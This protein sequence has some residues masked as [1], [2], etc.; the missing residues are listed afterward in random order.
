MACN[1]VHQTLPFFCGSG[2]RMQDDIILLITRIRYLAC[3]SR[4]FLVKG[5]GL[6]PRAAF[7]RKCVAHYEP[8]LPRPTE[9]QY[10][11]LSLRDRGTLYWVSGHFTVKHLGSGGLHII[12]NAVILC[13][14]S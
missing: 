4:D 11:Y 5:W 10:K 1:A 7:V 12:G 14:F 9:D 6:T 3:V 2:L 13:T 8:M